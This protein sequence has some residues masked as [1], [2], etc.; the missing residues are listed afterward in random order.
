[1][2]EPT[3]W[4][5]PGQGLRRWSCLAKPE[6]PRTAATSVLSASSIQAGLHPFGR[7]GKDTLWLTE[8][9]APLSSHLA[10]LFF[11]TLCVPA[12]AHIGAGQVLAAAVCFVVG[13][14]FRG[15]GTIARPVATLLLIGKVQGSVQGASQEGISFMGLR[16]TRSQASDQGPDSCHGPG[17]QGSYVPS[18]PC[19]VAPPELLRQILMVPEPS[20]SS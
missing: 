9:A 10:G 13:I 1:M 20:F 19:R 14:G 16:R 4:K 6:G 12:E 15:L 18:L 11:T 7:G 5:S 3:S 2:E 8:V 17:R